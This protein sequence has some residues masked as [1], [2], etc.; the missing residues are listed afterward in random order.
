VNYGHNDGYASHM[1]AAQCSRDSALMHA[2]FA[3]GP[4]AARP[5][6]DRPVECYR[7]RVH[8]SAALVV[9]CECDLYLDVLSNPQDFKQ[10][11]EISALALLDAL[12]KLTNAGGRYAQR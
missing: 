5:E 3:Y 4:K 9:L 6:I 12:A 8:L 10:L 11:R 1:M 7:F 2:G